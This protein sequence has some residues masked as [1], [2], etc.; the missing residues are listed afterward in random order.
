MVAD[1]SKRGPVERLHRWL[2]KRPD[3]ATQVMIFRYKLEE[4]EPV[5]SFSATMEPDDLANSVLGVM[6]DDA[7]DIGGTQ[8]YTICW[9]AEDGTVL[10]SKHFKVDG[11]SEPG[12]LPDAPDTPN[13]AGLVRQAMR[14][15]ENM[16]KLYLMNAG[17]VLEMAKEVMAIQQEHI[18]KLH[19]RLQVAEESAAPDEAL[20]EAELAEHEQRKETWSRAEALL[21]DII[22][23]HGPDVVKNVVNRSVNGAPKQSE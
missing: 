19:A 13:S 5:D 2:S 23:K 4:A 18:A 14:H 12:D 9:C 21:T 16:A 10:K 15:T 8:Q 11:E 17:S 22:K 1:T 6:L 7:D 20:L 3:K